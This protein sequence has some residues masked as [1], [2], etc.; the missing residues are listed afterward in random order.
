M[1]IISIFRREK[2]QLGKNGSGKTRFLKVL[3]QEK[4]RNKAKKETVI[5]L[6]FPEIHVFYNSGQAD[7]QEDAVCPY[8]LLLEHA[9]SSF[10]DLLKVMEN[11]KADFLDDILS[12]LSNVC[13]KQ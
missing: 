5:T 13:L 1:P 12:V 11:D 2:R 8:D 10:Y 7:Q 3:E 4:K 6:Y 9:E